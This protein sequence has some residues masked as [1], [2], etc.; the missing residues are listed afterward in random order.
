MLWT[1]RAYC[2]GI[3]VGVVLGV[4]AVHPPA[5]GAVGEVIA[6]YPLDG[7]NASAWGVAYDADSA[8]HRLF[9]TDARRERIEIFELRDEAL[10]HVPPIFAS[11]NS[12]SLRVWRSR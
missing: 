6:T 4:V 5:Q 12:S 1:R 9:V 11:Q 7:L 10:T 8:P 3:V 2:A